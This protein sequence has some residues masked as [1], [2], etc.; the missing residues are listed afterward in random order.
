LTNGWAYATFAQSTV[1]KLTNSL[2]QVFPDADLDGA[3]YENA[4]DSDVLT[5]FIGEGRVDAMSLPMV[6]GLHATVKRVRDFTSCARSS[7]A[8][9][10]ITDTEPSVTMYYY[11]SGSSDSWAFTTASL[12]QLSAE[13]QAD[14]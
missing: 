8:I 9:L 12:A 6:F 7:E 10:C 13:T 4:D 14:L 2:N 5:V 3:S 1:K 11:N